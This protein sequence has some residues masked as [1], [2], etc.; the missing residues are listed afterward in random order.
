[1]NKHYAISLFSGAGGLDLGIEAAGF[2][3]RLCTDIDDFSCKTLLLNK[4]KK[5][6]SFLAEATIAQKN[7]KEYS[8]EEILTDARL[9]K[10]EVDLVYGG[11]PCQAFSVF[12]K[13]QGINDPRGTLLWD[14]IRVIREIAPK[15]FIF[16]N[17][18]GLLTIDNGKIFQMLLDELSKDEN[19]KVQYTLSYALYNTAAYGI[20]QYRQRVIV[21]GIKG[22][23]VSPIPIPKATHYTQ[24]DVPEEGL[25]P[26][27]TVGDALRGLPETP[28]SDIPNHVGRVHGAA[29]TER[30]NNM[31]FGERDS[32]TRINRLDPN[33]ELYERTLGELVSTL[34]GNSD[35]TKVKRYY[36]P[37]SSSSYTPSPQY[38]TIDN[39][40]YGSLYR[41]GDSNDEIAKTQAV[42]AANGY[43]VGV[44]GVYDTATKNALYQYKQNND[45][46]TNGA[47]T[48]GNTTINSLN[49]ATNKVTVDDFNKMYQ[50]SGNK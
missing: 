21:Y 35:T 15:S 31:A 26:P 18:A 10:G 44:S 46:A 42:L 28:T 23:D 36:A 34:V 22:T 9:K 41:L 49:N 47:Y 25:L 4:G 32:K 12:G 27:V 16:E 13:R 11:P 39:V 29:V 30:Y 37:S 6:N 5:H 14:Y 8:T 3:T 19:G 7:I 33:K 50:S 17:V 38:I 45:I 24:P 43:D 2:T 20:P 1:M 48:Y 40:D